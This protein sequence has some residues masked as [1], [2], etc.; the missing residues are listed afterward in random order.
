MSHTEQIRT[1]IV[2]GM[3]VCDAC[4]DGVGSEC[5]TPDCVMFLSRC[6]DLAIRKNILAM[7][8]TITYE[9]P[10]EASDE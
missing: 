7:G 5:H 1:G 8:G 6:P 9:T 4:L 3:R 10:G 2:N